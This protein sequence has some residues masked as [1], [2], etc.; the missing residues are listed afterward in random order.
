MAMLRHLKWWGLRILGGI[1]VGA[2]ALI[3]YLAVLHYSGNFHTVIEGELYRSAQVTGTELA[4][5]TN[6]VS[7]KSVLNLRGPSPNSDWYKAE[8]AD[9]ARLGLVHAD[10]ALS[11][12]RQV[13]NEEA[14]ELI[15]L[16]RSLPKPLLIHCKHG[17]DRTGLMSALYMAAIAGQDEDT[18][19]AQLS[20]YFGHFSVPYLSAAY[21]MDE[22]WERLEG[23]VGFAE[24]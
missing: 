24:N 18:A 8:I 9:S 21:P 13:T 20:L 11:A 4:D 2:A 17:S 22:S 14:V 5:Y 6:K 7:L 15:A 23:M 16:M 10:F 3:G 1:G 19:E 12:S